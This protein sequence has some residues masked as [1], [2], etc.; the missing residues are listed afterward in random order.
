MADQVTTPNPLPGGA[1]VPPAAGGGADNAGEIS[2]AD[3]NSILGKEFKDKETALGAVK[4]T[5]RFVGATGQ[6]KAALDAAKAKLGTDDAGVI[7]ALA[8]LTAESQAKPTAPQGDYVPRS[9]YAED[10]FFKENAPLAALRETLVPLKNASEDT[11]AMSWDAFVASEKVKPVVEAY[12]GYQEAQG[13]KSILETSPRLG[14][15]SDKLTTA[16][17]SVEEANRAAMA[18]DVAGVRAHEEAA[19]SAAVGAVMETFK[20]E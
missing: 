17:K 5:F 11:K 13:K 8:N 4:E 16:R 7:A 3:I 18:N 14:A 20:D 12:T 15:A 6:V 1:D 9:Q 10:I 19:R 2:L